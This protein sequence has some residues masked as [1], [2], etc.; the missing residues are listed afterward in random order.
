MKKQANLTVQEQYH[1]ACEKQRKIL[2]EFKQYHIEN[3]DHPDEA[4]ADWEKRRA[5][6]DELRQKMI[7]LQPSLPEE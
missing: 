7:G 1:V 3:Y 5:E 2:E 6:Y 4:D